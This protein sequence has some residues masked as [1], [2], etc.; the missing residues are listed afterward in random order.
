MPTWTP[1]S[2]FGLSNWM[3]PIQ[4]EESFMSLWHEFLSG[5]FNGQT[6]EMEPGVEIDFP[7]AT[8]KCQ[9]TAQPQPLDGLSIS[10]IQ[11]FDDKLRVLWNQE[12]SSVLRQANFKAR[13][14]L[15]VR[16][17]TKQD[18]AGQNAE[19]LVRRGSDLLHG[20]LIHKALVVPL[21]RQGIQNIRPR[22]P[23]LVQDRDYK[24]RIIRVNMTLSFL[25][26]EPEVVGDES[27]VVG[28]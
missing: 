2:N 16:A 6:H 26:K 7:T 12:D 15:I 4:F 22:P 21:S 9:Q 13:A 17:Q 23:R 18:A 20:I 28:I 3:S 24:A 19:Y 8:I 14:D 10:V 5:W 1:E 27:S 11:H 25:V